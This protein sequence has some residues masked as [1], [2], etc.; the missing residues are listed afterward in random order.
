[1]IPAPLRKFLSDLQ[2]ATDDG[3]VTWSEG[4]G[5]RAY[6]CSKNGLNLHISYYFNMDEGVS[7]YNFSITGQKSASFSVSSEENDFRFME[8]FHSSV[9]VNANDLSD[10]GD[11]FFD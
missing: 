5:E 11:T 9:E 8:N 3:S 2:V 4:A 7:Y 6:V 1:M 10:I